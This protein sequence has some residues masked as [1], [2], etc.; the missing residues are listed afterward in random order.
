MAD[1]VYGR[2]LGVECRKSAAHHVAAGKAHLP[3]EQRKEHEEKV[4]CEEMRQR[5]RSG[6]HFPSY[7]ESH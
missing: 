4:L 3:M 2:S 6:E 5:A 1:D 7:W